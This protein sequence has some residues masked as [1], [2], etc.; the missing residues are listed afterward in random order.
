VAGPRGR[1]LY[2]TRDAALLEPVGADV[3]RIDVLP[4]AAAR[5]LLARLSGARA[6]ALPAAADRVIAATGRVALAL[7]LAGAAVGRGG[8]DW[9]EAATELE[10]GGDR[11]LDHPYADVFKAMDLAV[12]ALDDDLR[13]AYRSLAVFRRA[14]LAAVARLWAHVAGATT[15]QSGARL[16]M[17]AAREL[18]VR[19]GDAIVFHD[20]QHEF[21]LLRAGDLRLLHADLLEAYR[22]RGAPWSSLPPE[23][24]YIWERLVEHLRLAGDLADVR[25]VATD[26][27]YVAVR[28]WREGPYAAESELRGVARR[29]EPDATL[30]GLI[31]LLSRSGHLYAGHASLAD[32]AATIALRAR[33]GPGPL[34][35]LTRGPLL[36]PR[37]G[38][39]EPPEALLR[40]LELPRSAG[41][42]AFSPDGATL[43]TTEGDRGTV[44]LWGPAS[45]NQKAV[46]DAC[47]GVALQLAFSPD[48][49]ILASANNDHYVVLIDCAS[50]K[51]TARLPGRGPVWGVAFAP[52]GRLLASCG[53]DP[54]VRLWDP[55]TGALVAE[56]PG[57][58]HQV[59][60][61][62]FTPDGRRLASAGSDREV[63]LWDPAEGAEI[64]VLAAHAGSVTE[65]AVA[66]DGRTLASAG[67]DGDID[68]WDMATGARAGLLEGHADAVDRMA[69]TPDGR[70]LASAA[71]DGTVR[72]WDVATGAQTAVL[73]GVITDDR[74]T[75][76]FS[77]DGRTLASTGAGEG[78]VRLW[79]IPRATVTAAPDTHRG[80]VHGLALAPDGTR[81]A[82]AGDDATVRVWDAATGTQTAVLT[83]HRSEAR[84]VAFAPDGRT[85]ASA[86]RD[87]TVRLWDLASGAQRA[88]LEGHELQVLGVAFAPDGRQ[89]ATCGFDSTLRLWDA[90]TGAQRAL[91]PIK[92]RGDHWL[93]AITFAPDGRT[94]AS[95]GH[96]GMVRLWDPERARE[97][98]VLDARD[99]L[100]LGVAFAP[101]GRLLA[102]T[103]HTGAVH[104]WKRR[105]RR[106]GRPAWGLS[107]RRRR[108][109]AAL[110]GH[111]IS[112]SSVA[113]APDGRKLASGGGYDGT[114]RLWDVRR[115]APIY[116]ARVGSDV[117]A[118]V[119]GP[120]GIAVAAGSAVMMLDLVE[121]RAHG[122]DRSDS[123]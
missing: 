123:L 70:T 83:S 122:Q 119:W 112:T 28:C 75:V 80:D 49:R 53:D 118:V 26:L 7:A 104:L 105:G 111:A 97:T 44:R 115:R 58:T 62:A 87:G 96:D 24:P 63:R 78:I 18:L 110:E 16:D 101:G 77:S 93:N 116:V 82:S 100:V 52:D 38:M 88:V 29:Q 41:E 30:D 65:L 12:A 42:I 85:L 57:H 60:S 113:F 47:A 17:L 11:F 39:D 89:L 37:W 91:I 1:V 107:R 32:V 117:N 51:E 43:A 59:R 25:A 23:E 102:S 36:V 20:L 73:E 40:V 10:R 114:L 8:R 22:P 67:Y 45:G 2:T 98:A 79:D 56:F 90:A 81:L 46:L 14:P 54:T 50:G 19:D 55:A 69:F 13:A 86:G 108:P 27:A 48:G 3:H 31:A 109:T 33:G 68:L 76:A 34:R 71:R 66:P 6:D 64:G 92:G 106:W 5:E 72:L 103:G 61:V 99:P 94:L 95:A 9:D 35:R 15:E 74:P 21:L 120:D 121:P 84:D 4:D